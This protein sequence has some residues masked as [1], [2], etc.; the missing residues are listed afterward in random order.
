MPDAG[1]TPPDQGDVEVALDLL[2]GVL[3]SIFERGMGSGD[4]HAIR[5]LA[6]LVERTADGWDAARRLH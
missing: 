6:G 1:L 5:L 4:S 3:D 2:R